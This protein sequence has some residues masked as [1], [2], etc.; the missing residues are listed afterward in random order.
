MEQQSFRASHLVNNLLDLIANRPRSRELVSVG[1]LIAST[2]AL[3]DDL[4]KAKRINI[5]L[6]PVPPLKVRGNVHDLQQVLTNILLNARDAV[7]DGGNIWVAVAEED[8]R[9]VIRIRDDGKGIP[10]EMIG[11]IFEPLVTTKRGQGGTG[12]G[13]AISRRIITACDGD[14]TVNSTPGAG[15]EFSIALPRATAAGRDNSRAVLI[16]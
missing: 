9:V 2:I 14:I 1:D 12:L 8:E 5:H 6:A 11:R 4:L 10:P 13:L 15:A 16:Q 7:A 3:H